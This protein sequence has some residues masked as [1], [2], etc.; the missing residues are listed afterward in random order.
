MEN[1]IFEKFMIINTMNSN[2]SKHIINFKRNQSVFFFFKS[3][4]EKIK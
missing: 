3:V 1:F 4:L 2:I